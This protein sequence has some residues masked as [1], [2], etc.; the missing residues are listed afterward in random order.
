MH[1]L[2]ASLTFD[3]A[4]LSLFCLAGWTILNQSPYPKKVLM[5][6]KGN[7]TGQIRH[8]PAHTSVVMPDNSN[9]R[10]W[11]AETHMEIVPRRQV[12]VNRQGFFE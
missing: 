6:L 7:V 10:F 4:S 8:I 2:L 12:I 5:K 1:T 9:Y 11:D 3:P